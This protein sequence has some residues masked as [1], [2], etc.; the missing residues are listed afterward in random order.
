[1]TRVEDGTYPDGMTFCWFLGGMWYDES[2]EK[3]YAPMH[4]EHDGI[5]L[6]YP[7]PA[8]SRWAPAPTREGPGV[9][10][11]IISSETYYY[12]HDFFKFSGSGYGSGVA[13]F[14]FYVDKRGGYFYVFPDEGW[15]LRA[16]R[17]IR[18]N[19][20]AARCAIS[21]KMAPGKMEVFLQWEMG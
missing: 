1:M 21:D 20:R 9:T 3:L 5:R 13:D 14:G 17:G 12:T 15:E 8:R 11:D 7:F 2:E 18:W 6:S 4:I 10:K 16:S 19:S